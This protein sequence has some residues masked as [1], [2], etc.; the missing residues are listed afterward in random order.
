MKRN[1]PVKIKRYRRSFSGSGD[2][3]NLLRRIALWL[4]V[5]AAVFGAG[6][7]LAKPGLDFA[8]GLWYR[9]K[10]G[11]AA[12][13]A[14][15]GQQQPAGSGPA[16]SSLPQ[17][18]PPPEQQP[19]GG[20]W[21]AVP[22]SAVDTPEK[23][24]QT[25][26]QLQQ[27]GVQ[28]A[29]I[30]LKDDRGYL[31]YPSSQ[32]LAANSIS[33]ST[34]DA[35]AVADTLRSAGVTP[36]AGLCAFKDSIAPYTDR[37]AAVW[38]GDQGVIWLDTS[39][40]LG[41]K[42]WLNPNAPAA[43]QYIAGLI[44]EVREM[45]FEQVLLQDLQF[46]QGYGLEMAYYGQMDETRAGLLARL[47]QQYQAI[48]GVTVWFEFPAG[49]LSGEEVEPFGESPAGFG[50][51]R[52]MARLDTQ[53]VYNAEGQRVAQPPAADSAALKALLDPL[54]QGGCV[55][56]G[57]RAAGITDPQQVE[58]ACSRAQRAGFTDWFV[59]P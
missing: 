16:S 30:T 39:I 11:F 49:A 42:P 38:Y 5:L 34:V 28:A 23:A 9:L 57:L 3:N 6:W 10:A 37:E 47:G 40:E 8:S 7:L 43:Q 50:L 17:P 59:Q 2:R 53:W 48:E 12:P 55:A 33:A 26:R 19:Q 21:A 20:A 35:A 29:V 32:P 27:A 46:P 15:S 1:R 54:Q 41:G 44:E 4:V 13:P 56:F 31:Y 25:A 52:V 14:S 36:V 58:Q 51:Q 45:G 18:T 22:I 24:A